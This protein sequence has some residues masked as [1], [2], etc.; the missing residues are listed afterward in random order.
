[1]NDGCLDKVSQ[2]T[3]AGSCFKHR[4]PFNDDEPHVLPSQLMYYVKTILFLLR[5]TQNKRPGRLW[6]QGSICK[7]TESLDFSID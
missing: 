6:T 4:N 2:P 7:E 3:Y 1:M 5:R